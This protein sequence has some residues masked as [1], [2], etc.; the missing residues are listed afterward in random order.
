MEH[1]I[2]G[3]R[4]ISLKEAAARLGGKGRTT[5]WRW[6]REKRLPPPVITGPNSRGFFEDEF[7]ARI[8]ALPRVTYAPSADEKPAA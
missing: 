5:I 7:N 4:I 6:V 1:K 8:E 2:S 3:R